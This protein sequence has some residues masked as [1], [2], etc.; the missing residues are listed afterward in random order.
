MINS[1]NKI[2]HIEKLLSIKKFNYFHQTKGSARDD[3]RDDNFHLYIYINIDLKFDI[4]SL[5]DPGEAFDDS[6]NRDHGSPTIL[7]YLGRNSEYPLSVFV[8]EL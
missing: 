1:L 4:R 3:L 5:A 2:Y 7:L 8:T 6:S